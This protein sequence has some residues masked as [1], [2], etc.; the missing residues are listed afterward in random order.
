MESGEGITQLLQ[1][2]REAATMVTNAKKGTNLRID[3]SPLFL[4]LIVPALC[5]Q[6]G[7]AEHGQG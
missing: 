7:E 4:S 6:A 1:A 2:E 3:K 5:S